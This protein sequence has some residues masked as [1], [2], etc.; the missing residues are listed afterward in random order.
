[1][2]SQ[3]T[4][5]ALLLGALFAAAAPDLRAQTLTVPSGTPSTTRISEPFGGGPGRFQQIL[6]GV[7]VGPANFKQLAFRA[8][9]SSHAAHKLDMEL[10]FGYSAKSPALMST[11]FAENIASPLQVVV[12]RRS[13]NLP[14]LP[15]AGG[16]VVRFPFDAPF[17][18][19]GSGNL[20]VEAIVYANDNGNQPFY[21]DLSL[22]FS[23]QVSYVSTYTSPQAASGVR[24]LNQGLWTA[25]DY[26]QATFTRFGNGCPG[27]GAYIPMI[28]N[29]GFPRIGQIFQVHVTNIIG[30]RNTWLVLGRSKNAW[31][32]VPLPFDLT[33]FG[34]TGCTLYTDI[35][36]MYPVLSSGGLSGTGYAYTGIY[37][38]AFSGFVGAELLFQWLIHAPGAN[39]LGLALSDAAASRI[40]V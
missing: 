6:S 26:S 2:H 17:Q 3:K 27:E 34:A 13:V 7:T 21:Y 19:A 31:G 32:P 1:M 25:I 30:S 11:V 24:Y 40:D 23:T 20:L 16:F 35:V 36:F 5:A 14:A 33:S 18:Y 4:S 15:G 10:R 39:P 8:Y 28:S 12:S 37:V 29:V 9:G 38:P 22:A